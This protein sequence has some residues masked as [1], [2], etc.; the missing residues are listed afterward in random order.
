M[1]KKWLPAF[2]DEI[3]HKDMLCGLQLTGILTLYLVIHLQKPFL[4][5][6]SIDSQQNQMNISIFVQNYYVPKIII[7]SLL[8]YNMLN[9]FL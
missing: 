5:S 8:F 3:I 6:G 7:T 1:R 4:E 2:E 9:E